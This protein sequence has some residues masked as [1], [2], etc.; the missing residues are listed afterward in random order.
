MKR[1]IL[2]LLVLAAAGGAAWALRGRLAGTTTPTVISVAATTGDIEQVVLASGT[3][4]PARLVAVG[5][6]ASGRITAL[7]VRL[8]Q[9]IKAGDLVAE[10]DSLNQQNA[11]RTAEANLAQYRAQLLERQ[12]NLIL[13]E[14][15]LTRQR[16]T[17]AQRAT[18]AADFESAEATLKATQAQIEALEA[19]IR[20]AEVAVANAQVN[21]GYTRVTAPIDGTILAI[22]TQEGQTVNASQTAP[23]IVVM[24]QVDTMTV[25]AEISEAD[26]VRVRPGQSVYFTILGNPQRRFRATME[27]IDPAPDSIRSDSSIST[28]SSSASSSS[29]S[30]SSTSA[31]IYYYGRFNIANADGYLRTYMTAQVYVVLA[32]AKGAVLVPSAALRRGPRGAR[33]VRVVEASGAIVEREVQVGIDN[34][35][36]AEIRS[37]LAAGE[38]VVTGQRDA[39][40]PTAPSPMRRPP[41]AMG[42]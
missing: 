13:A 11:L 1:L 2:L 8:G 10:I 28:S 32:E 31:A 19:Q 41:G 35:I 26:V 3:L 38:R 4:K 27:S 37:G 12:A 6:Q 9:E 30:S 14:Q 23:T 42:L 24:G 29:S 7:K 5:A 39:G 15:T 17:L 18:S 20:A 16:R 33:S 22:V 40:A 25:F 34:R 36:M 21:L